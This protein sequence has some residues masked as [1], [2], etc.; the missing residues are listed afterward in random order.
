M[1]ITSLSNSKSQKF[2]PFIL[3]IIAV[4]DLR[5]EIRIL[6]DHVTITSIIYSVKSHPL[7]FLI[8]MLFPSLCKAYKAYERF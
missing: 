2:I 4:H 7:S 6:L 8:I 3:L 5:G 1:R